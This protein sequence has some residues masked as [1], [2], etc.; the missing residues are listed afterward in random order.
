V[1]T[2]AWYVTLAVVNDQRRYAPACECG[3]AGRSCLTEEVAAQ[4]ALEH[5][6]QARVAQ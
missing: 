6:R 3:W 5:V 4:T 2:H 1:T